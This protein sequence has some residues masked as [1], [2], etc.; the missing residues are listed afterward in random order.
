MMK[1]LHQELREAKEQ[2]SDGGIR[3]LK[4]QLRDAEKTRR[5]A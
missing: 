2:K 5:R 1:K 4:I 3:E